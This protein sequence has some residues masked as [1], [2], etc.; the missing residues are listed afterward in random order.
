[1]FV[2]IRAILDSKFNEI[3]ANNINNDQCINISK[4]PEF[5]YGWISN[6]TI[7]LNTR[8]IASLDLRETKIEDIRTEFL[9]ELMLQKYSRLWEIVNFKNFLSEKYELD[10]LYFYLSIRYLVFNGP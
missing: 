1:M 8:E 9:F 4:F 7:D 5:V 3:L 2:K 10:D 6:F